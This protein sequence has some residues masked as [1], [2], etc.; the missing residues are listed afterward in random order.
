M[1]FG[2]YPWYLHTCGFIQ[3]LS[4]VLQ[5]SCEEA[6]ICITWPIYTSGERKK[7]NQKI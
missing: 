6:E 1:L 5:N 4:E 2:S 3:L 7:K